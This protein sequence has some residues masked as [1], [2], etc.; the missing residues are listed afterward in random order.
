MTPPDWARLGLLGN[1]FE[2]VLPGTHL[3]WVEFPPALDEALARRPFRIEL[4][5]PKGAGKSTLLRASESRLLAA[6]L[7]VAYRYLPPGESNAGAWPE[8]AQVLLLDEADR[9]SRGSLRRLLRGEAGSVLLGTHRPVLE[10]PSLSLALPV[11]HGLGWVARRVAALT[12]PGRSPP[13]FAPWLPEIARACNGVN[14]A[15]LR[16]LYELAEELARG[17]PLDAATVA[18][19]LA[20]AR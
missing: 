3:D 14:Y 4:V 9:A 5:G 20:R 13:D 17:A 2:N 15:V 18:S 8:G 6:G 7:S 16:A 12:M 10:R 1:P 19:A 11:E